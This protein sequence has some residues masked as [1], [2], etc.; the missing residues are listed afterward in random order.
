VRASAFGFA[1]IYDKDEAE[2]IVE[3]TSYSADRQPERDVTPASD[4]TM[5]EINDLLISMDKSWDDD[6]LPFALGSSN[7]KSCSLPIL[8]KPRLL[9]LLDS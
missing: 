2:R 6:L 1:G 5:K 4:S 8:P 7:A 9:K 3:S